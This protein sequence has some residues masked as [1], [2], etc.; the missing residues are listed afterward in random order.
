MQTI[1]LY[2]R[3]EKE[4]KKAPE[5]FLLFEDIILFVIIIFAILLYKNQFHIQVRTCCEPS[6]KSQ[7][8]N[9]KNFSLRGN[10]L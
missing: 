8:T 9:K 6:S 5:S 2:E 10:R 4:K 7:T 1:I 3:K